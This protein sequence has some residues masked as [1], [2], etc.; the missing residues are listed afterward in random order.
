MSR[1]LFGLLALIAMS[2]EANTSPLYWPAMP[3]FTVFAHDSIKGVSNFATDALPG[4]RSAFH[5]WEAP[6]CTSWS[7]TEDAQ[8]TSPSGLDAQQIDGVNRV[9]WLSGTDWSYDSATVGLTLIVY[10][11]ATN[12]IVDADMLLN[13][14]MSWRS[15]TGSVGYD[16]ETIVLHEAGHF[17]GL[18]HSASSAAVMYAVASLENKRALTQDDINDVCAMYPVNAGPGDTTPPTVSISSPA[19]DATYTSARTV[20]LTAAAG[21]DVGISRVELYDGSTL[22]RTLTASP[23]S[24]TW[25][26]TSSQNGLHAWTAR[27]YDAAGNVTTSATRYLS[28]KINVVVGVLEDAFVQQSNPTAT[29]NG[30]TLYVGGGTTAAREAYLKFRV[31]G[32]STAPITSAR[33]RIYNTATV[34]DGPAAFACSACAWA[35]TT[36]SWSNRPPRSTGALHDKGALAFGYNDYFVTSAVQGNGTYTF[37]LAGGQIPLSGQF[38]AKFGTTPPKLI[39]SQ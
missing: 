28:V 16:V 14:N 36:L 12:Q 6:L 34:S 31:Q 10:Q 11:T 13:N 32:L 8:F 38:V 30:S 15:A 2:A 19:T 5:T 27:A 24:H 37:V 39:I 4:V 9:I 35:E 7:V 18:E 33:L 25:S 26:V 29:G 17:L 23:Y 22:V 20:T 1:A 21:D 3:R